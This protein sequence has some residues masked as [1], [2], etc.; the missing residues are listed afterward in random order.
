MTTLSPYGGTLGRI[1][2]AVIFVQAGFAKIGGYAGTQGYMEAM[3]VPGILL[4]L[5]ILLEAG[6]GLALV[7]GWQTRIA[8]LLLAAFT[9]LAAVLFHANF[10][11]Q[12][13][14]IMF[15]KNVAIA[16]G[17]LL[18]AAHGGG[19]LALDNRRR[20]KGAQVQAAA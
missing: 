11:D 17:L 19:A 9:L 6:A 2:L 14:A 15:M 7:V 1:L 16:G 12:M 3:G 13:Q 18:L 10:A 8:A 20:D 4:P 5:V